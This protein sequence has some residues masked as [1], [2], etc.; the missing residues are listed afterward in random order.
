[1]AFRRQCLRVV[2]ESTRADH[3]HKGAE[4]GLLSTANINLLEQF[5]VFCKSKVIDEL[6]KLV[7]ENTYGKCSFCLLPTE[8]LV[9][10]V[11]Q[12]LLDAAQS[13]DKPKENNVAPPIFV[14]KNRVNDNDKSDPSISRGNLHCSVVKEQSNKRF[15]EG[16]FEASKPIGD[17]K[18]VHTTVS[19]PQN[20]A[21]SRGPPGVAYGKSMRSP[22]LVL[23]TPVVLHQGY[24]EVDEFASVPGNVLIMNK[25]AKIEAP[26]GC[27]YTYNCLYDINTVKNCFLGANSAHKL[28]LSE[29]LCFPIILH[30]HWFVFIVDLKNKLFV[31]LDSY[32]SGDHNFQIEARTKL[33][34]DCGVF[35]LKFMELWD[36]N[37]DLKDMFDHSD[38]PNIRIKLGVDLF[39]SK[40]NCIDKSLLMNLYKQ[41]VD[42]R[43]CN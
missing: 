6:C 25:K 42:P 7:H 20:S 29:K 26:K 5:V 3:C 38:I 40:G 35:A 32:F 36:R 13:A 30:K 43:V 22:C 21:A 39:F 2:D 33:S 11:L 17:Q 34:V 41:G 18:N 14:Q 27:L 10:I 31:F 24:R 12:I 37:V 9:L 16:N 28:H 15:A 4:P 23:D 8:S 19:R 1:M